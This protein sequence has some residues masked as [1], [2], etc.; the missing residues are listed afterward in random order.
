MEYTTKLFG[1]IDV[2]EDKIIEFPEGI[3][4]FENLKKFA[5]I[6]DVEKP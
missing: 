3:L 6:Y 2:N 5:L 4:G 1:K